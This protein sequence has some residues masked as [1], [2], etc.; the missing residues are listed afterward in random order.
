LVVAGRDSRYS[1]YFPQ[2]KSVTVSNE[3][4]N[5][6]QFGFFCMLRK[7]SNQLSVHGMPKVQQDFVSRASSICSS[8][9]LETVET[10]VTWR[11]GYKFYELYLSADR[12]SV[13]V[14]DWLLAHKSAV[15]PASLDAP[16]LVGAK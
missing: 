16:K 3:V 13:S 8:T 5:A 1:H 4:V 7:V 12:L 11:R 9:P 15:N 10:G 2:T 6:T 14:D